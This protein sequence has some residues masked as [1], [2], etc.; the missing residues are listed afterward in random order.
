MR[1]FLKLNRST[2]NLVSSSR[3]VYISGFEKED[4]KYILLHTHS[5]SHVLLF[6]PYNI[7]LYSY[8]NIKCLFKI[9]SIRDLN[10]N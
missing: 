3:Y 2:H 10:W 9:I 8:F 5:F 1:V 7:I 4:S 6:H